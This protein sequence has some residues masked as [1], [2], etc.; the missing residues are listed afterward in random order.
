MD[1][2][3][4]KDALKVLRARGETTLDIALTA[5]VNSPWTLALF[6]AWTAGCVVVGV[7]IAR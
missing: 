1:R 7:W 4:I 2:T 5:A 6:A 3:E